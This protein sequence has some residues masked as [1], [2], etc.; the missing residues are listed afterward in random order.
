MA[1]IV[2]QNG[3][4]AANLVQAQW[5]N[6][7]YNLLTGAM[8][9]QPVTINNT[10]ML[11][12]IAYTPPAAPTLALVAGTGMGTGAYTYAITYGMGVG[13]TL[14]GTTAT[15]TTTSTSAQVALSNIPV[16]PAGTTYRN[17]YRSK[18]GTSS[19]LYLVT[20]IGN[21]TTTTYTD[22]AADTALT[23]VAGAHDKFGGYLRMQDQNGI[24]V[25]ELFPDG[26]VKFDTGKIITDG[27]GNLTISNGTFTINGTS[28]LGTTNV[29]G[30][31]AMQPG[32][33]LSSL[34][35][36]NIQAISGPPPSGAQTVVQAGGSLSVG[37]YQYAYTY[38]TADGGE[39]ALSPA[40]SATTTTGNTAVTY[41][42]LGVGPTGTTGRK[43]YRTKVGGS[44]FYFLRSIDN[45]VSYVYDTAA[46]TTLTVVA[47]THPT[48][49]G[50]LNVKDQ[51]GV[52]Q[53]QITSDGRLD[54]NSIA[55]T[56]GSISRFQLFNGSGAQTITH[57]WGIAPDLV[58]VQYTGS[59]GSPPSSIPVVTGF[60]T[61][62]FGVSA[63]SAYSWL[64]VAIKF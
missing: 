54:I 33:L 37:A 45:A 53:A 3:T 14:P 44:T 22:T 17:I 7:Y 61:T 10:L 57:N 27:N 29:Y 34:G 63:Q 4:G 16:G 15:V 13:Q 30:P 62:T 46:D 47:P 21:N 1:L 18:V 36:V 12:Q 9:D 24:N 6:D 35:N 8:A 49:G 5:F 58:L 59:F 19:P 41:Q 42:S 64:A 32:Q 43:V 2:R 38:T 20:T 28:Y 52:V 56:S 55:L 60:S 23:S 26:A 51:N 40:T 31:L 50:T 39:T 25:I 48:F 11:K